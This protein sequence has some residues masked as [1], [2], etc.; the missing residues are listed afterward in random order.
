[1]PKIYSIILSSSKLL[2]VH[3]APMI[4]QVL[5]CPE[6]G[7]HKSG[8]NFFFVHYS[9]LS[10]LWES[11]NTQMKRSRE[12]C[13]IATMKH[14]GMFMFVVLFSSR[15]VGLLTVL[16]SYTNVKTEWHHSPQREI[17]SNSHGDNLGIFQH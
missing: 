13:T 3:L 7:Q 8:E 10:A 4:V 9:F 16:S 11:L 5:A 6:T 1:M 12:S 2:E 17:F 14:P 15:R